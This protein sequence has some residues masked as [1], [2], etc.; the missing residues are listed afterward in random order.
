M[1]YLNLDYS[2]RSI[3]R[4]NLYYPMYSR[5]VGSHPNEQYFKKQR[6]LN[7]NKKFRLSFN[8]HNTKHKRTEN[9]NYKPD[10]CF[11][12]GSEDQWIID[13][14]KPKNPEERVH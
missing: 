14:P 10:M 9:N 4:E 8:S 2:I 7:G 12:C 13:F 1:Y 3:G 5:C 6:K 11:I